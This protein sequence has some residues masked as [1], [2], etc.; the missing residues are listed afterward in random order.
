MAE[1]KPLV[2]NKTT[3]WIEELPTGDSLPG[4]GGDVEVGSTAPTTTDGSVLWNSTQSGKE[5]VYFRDQTRNK[6]LGDI[7]PYYF[8]KDSADNE[9]SRPPGILIAGDFVGISIIQDV[10]L[11]AMAINARDMNSSELQKTFE[12]RD[13]N[14]SENVLLGSIQVTRV[15]APGTLKYSSKTLNVD[16]PEGAIINLFALP[17]GGSLRDYEIT[18][19]ARK[20]TS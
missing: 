16:I 13:V 14:N 2:I 7:V 10:T 18:M 8:G 11:V 9:Y 12:L 19:W 1:R 5:G 3:G 6:W 15:S 20:R 4:G 17:S